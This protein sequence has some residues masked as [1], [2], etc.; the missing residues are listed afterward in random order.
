[1]ATEDEIKLLEAQAKALAKKAAA[2]EKDLATLKARQSA[3]AAITF[4]TDKQRK[5][6]E[7]LR[8][9]REQ[10]VDLTQ[11][12]LDKLFP[13]AEERR[14]ALDLVRDQNIALSGQKRHLDEI[15]DKQEEID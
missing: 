10:G 7:A 9:A 4:E 5:N 12:Q 6:Y 2:Q 1:M 11:E 8:T 14:K 15:K 13:I 3:E